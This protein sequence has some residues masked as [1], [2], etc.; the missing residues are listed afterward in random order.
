MPK[1]FLCFYCGEEFNSK[2]KTRDH[3]QPRS[4]E[5]SSDPRNL[6][7]SCKPC[8]SLKSSLTLEEF[9][10]VVAYQRGLIPAVKMRFPGEIK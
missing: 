7:D 8:N 2:R 5:G 1:T 6:V 4:R 9:R 10:L 3:K